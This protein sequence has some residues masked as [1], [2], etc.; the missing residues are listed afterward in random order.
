MSKIWTDVT[1][2]IHLCFFFF[3][4]LIFGHNFEL[5][6]IDLK[7]ETYG[8]LVECQIKSPKYLLVSKKS[9]KMI[10]SLDF[11]N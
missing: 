5:F 7:C 10:S 4:F 6:F 3:F 9:V 8:E 11:L 1:L 2:L